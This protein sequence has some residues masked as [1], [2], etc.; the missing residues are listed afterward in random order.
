MSVFKVDKNYKVILNAD[1]AKLIPEL[2]HLSEDV[3]LYVIL[4]ADYCD[5]PYRK[6]PIEERRSL[7]LKRVFGDKPINVDTKEILNAIDSY[8]SLVFDI[9][10]ETLDVYKEKVRIYHKE[11][12]NPN[13]EIKRL[14]ELDGA[15]QFLT[16]RIEKVE[17][18][19]EADDINEI[20]LK[21]QK[22]LSYIE[23]WQ[24]RQK[25]FRKFKEA[26]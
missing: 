12:L 7:A 11:S 23:I 14:K 9:R 19:L 22:K 15:I 21:G 24:M 18:S 2:A 1:A 10:R 20:E 8:K 5:G 3:L 6:K 17:V 16:E 4:V 25:E 13:M 26:T